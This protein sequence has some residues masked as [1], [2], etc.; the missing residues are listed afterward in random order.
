LSKL[1]AESYIRLFYELYRLPYTILSYANVYG[2]RQLP[3]GEGGVVSVFLERIKLGA[4]LSVHGDGEQTRDFIFVSDIVKANLAALDRGNQE[5]IQIGTSQRTSINEVLSH[6]SGIHG[7]N[8]E[9]AST[10]RRDGDI[11]HSCLCNKKAL[12]LLGWSPE[13]DIKKGLKETYFYGQDRL[14]SDWGMQ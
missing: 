14:N 13:I 5:T 11:K 6:L 9:T 10:A 3:K 12:Q 1:T 2:P 4:T 7:F 8:V